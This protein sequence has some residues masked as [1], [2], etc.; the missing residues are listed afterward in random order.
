[1]TSPASHPT[2]FPPTRKEIWAWCFYDFGNSAFTTIIV[3]VA[4]SVYFTQVVAQGQ[5]PEALWGRGYA[6][7]MILGGLLSPVLGALADYSATRKLQLILFT[8]LTLIPTTLMVT[9]RPGDVLLGIGL[10]VLANLSYNTALALYDS[11][12]KDLADSSNMGR[13][14]GYGWSFGYIGGLL[15]L[16]AVYPFIQGGYAGEDPWVYRLSFPITALFYLVFSIPAF[17]YLKERRSKP[18]ADRRISYWSVGFRRVGRTFHELRRFRELSKYFISFL[19][20]SD[21]IHTIIVF[22]AIFATKVL[23]F[24][25]AD[26]ILY[27][28]VMQLSSAAGAYLF[29][30]V[31]DRIGPKRTILITLVVWIAIIGWT[32]FVRSKAEFYLIGLTA[33]LSLGSSQSASRTLLGLLTPVRRSGEFF[34]F[35]SLTGKVAATIG[36]LL[37]GEIAARTGDLRLAVLSIGLFF[38]A[39]FLGLLTVNEKE[40][41][42]AARSS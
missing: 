2:P 22:A 17:L 15:S 21:G 40:G 32:Y 19:I 11:F 7:S 12:L 5:S 30:F 10:F 31:T 18:P 14:S 4:Y 28:T 6:L 13:I 26:L 42:E 3:T 37:F 29:G 20:Y 25:P 24:T 27:F 39:G 36:P 38:I 23:E 34:G 9:V 35:F 16:L 8:V 1:M 33:G 41:I